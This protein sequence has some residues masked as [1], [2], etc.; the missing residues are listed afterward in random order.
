M[1]MNPLLFPVWFAG[2]FGFF[3]DKTDKRMRMFGW[4]YAAVTIL[5]IANN[6]KSYYLA[7]VYAFL[8]A[9]GAIA[10]EEGITWL[11]WNRLKPV[12][13]IIIAVL[14]SVAVPLAIPILPPEAFIRY[15]E[16]LGQKPNSDENQKMGKLPQFFADRQGW[17]ELAKTVSD[18]YQQLSVEDKKKCTIMAKNY[19]EAGA[20]DFWGK[21]YGLPKVICGHNNYFY[22]GPGEATG[23]IMIFAGFRYEEL[24]DRFAEVK[25]MARTHSEYAMPY[26]SDF[27]G[28]SGQK[29]KISAL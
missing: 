7:P 8:F 26:E 14:G 28:F 10:I 27:T 5:L 23:E 9:R 22:W 4:I 16:I 2:L 17:P 24:K 6:G 29:S 1:V 15:S 12:F 19:G 21:Q 11:Q 25:E 3:L 18:V 13:C 20:I